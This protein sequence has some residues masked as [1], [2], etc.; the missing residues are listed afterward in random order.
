MANPLPN[1]D[2]LT[3]WGT[4]I[5]ATL[6]FLEERYDQGKRQRV[7]TRLSPASRDV[8]V[9]TV[10]ASSHYPLRALVELAEATD[11]ECA[12]GDLSLCAEMGRFACD[13]EVK[14]LH[15][16]FLTI[17]SLDYWFRIAGSMW[18]TYYSAGHMAPENFTSTGGRLRLDE[19]NPISKAF[20]Y[21]FGGWAHRICELSR[22]S[23]VAIVHSQCLLDGA[24]ACVWDA[25]WAGN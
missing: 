10:L 1:P 6:A 14:T 8:A 18:K 9:G 13:Y 22:L 2:S 12:R 5:K 11:A 16:V 7:I 24:P 23:G 3:C 19:F 25:T 20:C 17:A 21:R 15:R 4:T